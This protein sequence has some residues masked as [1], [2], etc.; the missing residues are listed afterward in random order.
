MSQVSN[1]DRCGARFEIGD[2][3]TI[4]L[5]DDKS[6]ARRFIISGVEPGEA[7]IV[8]VTAIPDPDNNA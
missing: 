6:P 7:G 1:H 4:T 3:V 5:P 2:L 8:T